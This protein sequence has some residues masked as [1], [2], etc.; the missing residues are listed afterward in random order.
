MDSLTDKNG[1]D[2]F[3]KL[4]E[5]YKKFKQIR[6]KAL[7]IEEVEH[8]QRLISEGW[9]IHFIVDFYQLYSVAY[10]E[11]VK[12][13]SDDEKKVFL[14]FPTKDEKGEMFQQRLKQAIPFFGNVNVDVPIFIPPYAIEM[15]QKLRSRT[16]KM[17]RAELNSRLHDRIEKDARK[18]HKETDKAILKLRE[19][20]IP[21]ST[22]IDEEV[23]DFSRATSNGFYALSYKNSA[24]DLSLCRI[25]LDDDDKKH[26]RQLPQDDYHLLETEDYKSWLTLINKQ[27]DKP[28]SNPRDA[29]AIALTLAL[30]MKY[31]G[32]KLFLFL[33]DDPSIKKVLEKLRRKRVGKDKFK[34]PSPFIN[35]KNLPH[36]PSDG[37]FL[38]RTSNH[39]EEFVREYE[40]NNIEGTISNLVSARETILRKVEPIRPFIEK[41]FQKCKGRRNRCDN[42]GASC[43]KIFIYYKRS[44]QA[45]DKRI[46]LEFILGKE[47]VFEPLLQYVNRYILQDD[48]NSDI[49]KLSER[50]ASFFSDAYEPEVLRKLE[51]AAENFRQ[52]EDEKL[53]QIIDK[54]ETDIPY[55]QIRHRL[56]RLKGLILNVSF[57]KNEEIQHLL[58]SLRNYERKEQLNDIRNKYRAILELMSDQ[59]EVVDNALLSIIILYSYDE[60]KKSAWLS[61]LWSHEDNDLL[62]KVLEAKKQVEFVY[63]QASSEARIC[64]SL[65]DKIVGNKKLSRSIGILKAIQDDHPTDP[66]IPYLLG[67]METRRRFFKLDATLKPIYRSIEYC[68]EALNLLDS[69]E[70]GRF[71]SLRDPLYNNQLYNYIFFTEAD[72]STL[73]KIENLYIEVKKITNAH[74]IETLACCHKFYSTIVYKDDL[75]SSQ[76]EF[77]KAFQCLIWAS[78]MGNREL[79]NTME[80][81]S[82]KIQ[83]EDWKG[84]YSKLYS[85]DPDEYIKKFKDELKQVKDLHSYP[86]PS[87][88]F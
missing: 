36:H 23:E 48:G 42:C 11:V 87:P 86:F 50:Y 47:K 51:K 22:L 76:E 38:L 21:D 20:N 49:A 29:K 69:D 40:M 78:E 81:K 37:I 46:N 28:F 53:F 66:R 64:Y 79:L 19:S 3:T 6:E 17:F 30:N 41:T 35:K 9:E 59:E 74:H 52:E 14:R 25:M 32:K 10:P 61:K 27:R 57:E 34:D 56:N 5:Y 39:F 24:G 16:E 63:M 45:F 82:L 85:S 83:L 15:Q 60:Y 43:E 1:I 88:P 68:N 55:L 75:K 72:P 44:L 4:D 33:S 73:T 70:E 54:T 8:D 13:R 12:T 18:A 67:K 84:E 71:A 26:L 7:I 58:I 80:R 65:K 2:N 77:K 31:D 62:K